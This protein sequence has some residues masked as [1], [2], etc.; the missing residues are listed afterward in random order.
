MRAMDCACSTVRL[1]PSPRECGYF[2]LQR[3]LCL[4]LALLLA[5]WTF[6]LPAASFAI[7]LESVDVTLVDENHQ[8]LGR[9]IDINNLEGKK[10]I[11]CCKNGK[12]DYSGAYLN[13]YDES[14][15]RV[16]MA[17]EFWNG[18]NHSQGHQD[19]AIIIKKGKLESGKKY[20]FKIQHSRPDK[21]SEQIYAESEFSFSVGGTA[22]D[23]G[24]DDPAADDSKDDPQEPEEPK[25]DEKPNN[26]NNGQGDN[27]GSG[28]GDQSGSSGK[29]G[30]GSAASASKSQSKGD[31][32][33]EL[34]PSVSASTEATAA[35]SAQTEDEKPDKKGS[36]TAEVSDT[37]VTLA[38]M[39]TVYSLG[40]GS[41]SA[42]GNTGGGE[43]PL[44]LEVTGIPWLLAVLIAVL[45]LAL[46]AGAAKRII[47]A[48]I[49]T[50]RKSRL[51]DDDACR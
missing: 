17:I 7:E 18:S 6:A 44:F 23:P 20:T 10:L 45:T 22:E 16:E 43:V 36:E 32:S 48:V 5:L 14:G 41:S 12:T 15:D 31:A 33:A 47:F 40:D 3:R 38:A 25:N 26:G 42:Q 34:K 37:S 13:L 50:R 51:G 27:S 28:K 11:L 2:E 35:N 24:T 8:P 1:R 39:G 19:I 49:G 9:D 4:I 21:H 30:K 46:P 29:S